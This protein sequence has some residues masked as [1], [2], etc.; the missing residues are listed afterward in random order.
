MSDNI[1]TFGDW[2]EEY[3]HDLYNM[4]NIIHKKS[5]G[6]CEND[7]EI[8]NKFCLFVFKKDNFIE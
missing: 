1:V 6:E 7:W 2:K 8:F 5:R 4:F 3:W